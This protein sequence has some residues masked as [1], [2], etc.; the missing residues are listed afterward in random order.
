MAPLPSVAA[1]GALDSPL[2]RQVA[3]LWKALATNT[4]L[5]R[6]VMTLLYIKLK[7]RPPELL[8]RLSE[9]AELMSMLVSSPPCPARSCPARTCCCNCLCTP[10]PWGRP[11][12]RPRV[13]P[14]VAEGS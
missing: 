9:Q 4:Q 14:Q 6:K 13:S 12:S 1:A 3:P 11:G 7:L 2:C 10:G 5:A 8:I